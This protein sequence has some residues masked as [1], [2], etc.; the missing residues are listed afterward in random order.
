VLEVYAVVDGREYH[1]VCVDSLVLGDHLLWGALV[2]VTNTGFWR[3]R[4]LAPRAHPNDGRADVVTVDTRMTPR[5]RLSA[6]HRMRWGTHLPHPHASVEQHRAIELDGPPRKLTI[7]GVR[8][9]VATAVR[10]R[11]Q[12]DALML[13]V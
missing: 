6:W 9:G 5:Q 12:P 3:G 10:I 13:Y 2:I 4:R 7:D 11:V 1:G 8:V